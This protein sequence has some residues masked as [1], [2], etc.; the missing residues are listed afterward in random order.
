MQLRDRDAERL[1]VVDAA[2][3]VHRAGPRRAKRCARRLATQDCAHEIVAT[4][5]RQPQG[6]SRRERRQR[7]RIRRVPASVDPPTAA[8]AARAADSAWCRPSD[9]LDRAEHEVVDLPAVP[10]PHFE[11]RRMRVHIHQLRVERQI[12]HVRRMAAAIEHIAIRDAHGVHQQPVAHAAAVHEPELLIGCAREAVGSPTQPSIANRPRLVT[13]RHGA[14]E[15]FLAE[16]GCDA[17]IAAEH[18]RCA[19]PRAH[20]AARA[21]R[22]AGG[23]RHRSATARAVRRGARCAPARWRRCA[24]TCAAPAR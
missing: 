1:I 15:E 21:R 13:H 20:R 19:T 9:A 4:A 8:A 6:R 24:R 17:R 22:C 5:R 23:T 18:R 12:Q 11:L 16:H 3:G 7:C 2:V 10:E 14:R